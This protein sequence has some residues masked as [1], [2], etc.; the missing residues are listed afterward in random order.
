M[1]RLLTAVTLL[2]T[3]L[4]TILTLAGCDHKTGASAGS[5]PPLTQVGVATP[6]AMQL[7]ATA[8]LTGSIEALQTVELRPRV[9]GIIQKVLVEDGASVAAGQ[10]LFQIDEAPLRSALAHAQADLAGAQSRLQM[11]RQHYQRLQGLVAEK[12]VSQQAYDDAEDAVSADSAAVAGTQASLTD[13]QLN[14]G[15]ATLTAPMAGRLGKVLANAGNLAQA[16]AT[17][18]VTL[19]STDPVYVTCDLDETTWRSVA[20]RLRAS[21]DVRGRGPAAVKV[22]VALPGEQGYPHLGSVAFVDNQIDS[23]SGSIRI[24]ALLPN[25]DG[26]LT[27]GAFARVQLETEAPRPVLLINEQVVLAQL[28]TRYVLVVDDQGI[29]AFRPVQLGATFGALRIVTSG[30]GANDHVAVNNLAK[31]F[32]PGMPVAPVPALMET[33][34]NV[35]DALPA[36][37]PLGAVVAIQAKAGSA[38]DARSK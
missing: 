14:L 13:A 3:S 22:G 16:N 12:I 19:V 24:R 29:T 37:A 27:P 25:A 31:I 23:A 7:P 5:T 6:I 8:E 2:T 17:L 35:A 34:E 11:S 4:S 33:T 21:A 28:T 10:V 26:A 20:E 18:L 15:Y 38:S 36:C 9:G 1:I 30:L 32:F